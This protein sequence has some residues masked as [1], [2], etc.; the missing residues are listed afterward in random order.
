MTSK[1]NQSK[2]KTPEA[3]GARTADETD[4]ASAATN[5]RTLFNAIA[6]SYDRLNHLLSF[7]LDR[8]WWRSTAHTFRDILARPEARVLDICC[9][10][11]D[12]TSALLAERPSASPALSPHTPGSPS[13]A[14]DTSV[15]ITREGIPVEPVTGLDFSP[16][17]LQRART[18]YATA[19]AL[20][21]EG[22][23]MHLPYPDAS[24]DLVTA[25]FGF[26]NLSNYPDALT[27]IFRVLR[28]GGQVGILECNHPNGLSGAFYLLYL[29]YVLP[30][31]GGWISGERA[32]YKYL[33]ASIARFPRPPRMKQ[34]IL[35]AGFQAPT[36]RGYFL[37]AAGL[38]RATKP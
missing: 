22:D 8:R 31:I 6:P 2:S 27:E 14:S 7:G 30:I 32:A 38:Y 3:T 18:K 25:A 35:E 5:V 23:A 15:S 12:M 20:W 4:E 24:F 16:E 9:G 36:W 11:G 33:P 26:R 37:R 34:M 10:T 13:L 19:N 17:M 29:N 28:P 1:F 21:V